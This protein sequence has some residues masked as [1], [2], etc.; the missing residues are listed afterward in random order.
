MNKFWVVFVFVS[1]L[2]LAMMILMASVANE[3]VG[4]LLFGPFLFFVGWLIVSGV[5]WFAIRSAASFLASKYPARSAT[6]SAAA[7][8]ALGSG[9][10]SLMFY[11]PYASASLTWEPESAVLVSLI[12]VFIFPGVA[13]VAF[14]MFLTFFSMFSLFKTPRISR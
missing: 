6:L 9:V 5:V 2:G 7:A 11:L 4:Q 12:Q 10:Q 1:S 3:P 8:L 13:L 14:G